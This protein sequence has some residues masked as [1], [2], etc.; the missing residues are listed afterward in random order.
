M[1]TKMQK[2]SMMKKAKEL[3]CEVMA[4]EAIEEEIKARKTGQDGSYVETLISDQQMN[5]TDYWMASWEISPG[6]NPLTGKIIRKLW[7]EMKL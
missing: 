6:A 7:K 5:A 3:M 4:N 1:L 2:Q